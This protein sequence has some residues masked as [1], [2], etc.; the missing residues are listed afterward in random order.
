MSETFSFFTEL[1]RPNVYKV[2][3]VWPADQL[4]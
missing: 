2:G 3:V 4:E 1:K